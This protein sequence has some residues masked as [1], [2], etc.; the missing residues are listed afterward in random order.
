MSGRVVEVA[1]AIDPRHAR[2]R[3]QDSS[4]RP[5][6]RRAIGRVRAS[7]ALRADERKAL[8][9]PASAIVRRG[10]LS[11]VFVVDASRHARMRAVTPG[12]RAGESV[13]VLAGM[14]PGETVVVNPPAPLVDGTEVRAAGG[15]P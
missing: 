4:C 9:V 15:R 7:A 11:L 12:A 2:I 3:R 5:P 14:Q 1:R 8:V 13:E 6:H 10:Q